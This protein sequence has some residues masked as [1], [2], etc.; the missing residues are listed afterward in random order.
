MISRPIALCALALCLGA[1]GG[2]KVLQGYYNPGRHFALGTVEEKDYDKTVPHLLKDLKTVLHDHQ[3]SI[4]K[5]DDDAETA[6]LHAT[7]DGI[8]YV[9]EIKSIGSGSQLHI[10]ADQAGNNKVL[11]TIIREIGSLP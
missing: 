6:L 8:D 7:K 11:W 10:E 4:R 2:C 1:S 9:F 3:F 5:V